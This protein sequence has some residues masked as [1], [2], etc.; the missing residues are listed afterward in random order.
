MGTGSLSQGQKGRG[1]ALTTH[2]HLGIPV[3]RSRPLWPVLGRTL[4]FLIL[5]VMVMECA[6]SGTRKGIERFN[7]EALCG[8][9][10]RGT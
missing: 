9:H 5:L 1:M 8:S 2:S 7:F 10:F 3:L 6:C 4:S